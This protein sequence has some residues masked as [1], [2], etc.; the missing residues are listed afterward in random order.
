MRSLRSI[1]TTRD[2]SVRPNL[3]N[4]TAGSTAS[5]WHTDDS[6]CGSRDGRWCADSCG[7]TI[8]YDLWAYSMH[9]GGDRDID[10][11]AGDVMSDAFR[12]EVLGE[13]SFITMVLHG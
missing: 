10:R 5:R 2:S 12:I 1:S 8:S 3:R 4:S 11:T 13:T 7:P 6:R 9:A